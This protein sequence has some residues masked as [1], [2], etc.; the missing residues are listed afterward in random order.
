[1]TIAQPFAAGK[2]EVTFAEWDACVS[3]GGC[4]HKPETD[5]GRGRQPV[6]DV[7]WDD[8]TKEYLPWLR[9]K[10]GKEYRLLSEAEWEYAARA[11]TTTA[12]GRTTKTGAIS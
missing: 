9:Q 7:S 4:K 2:F 1:M 10:T 3:E 6:M 8:I 12:P 11:G 5:W